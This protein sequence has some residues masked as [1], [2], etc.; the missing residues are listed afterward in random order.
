MGKLNQT[1]TSTKRYKCFLCLEE[2][3]DKE[4]CVCHLDNMHYLIHEHDFN[5]PLEMDR[6]RDN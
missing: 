6:T 5:R 1:K 2:M 3:A 4:T